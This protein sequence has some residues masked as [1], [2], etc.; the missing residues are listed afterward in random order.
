[1]QTAALLPQL[2]CGLR[3]IHQACYEVSDLIEAVSPALR[4][5]GLHTGVTQDVILRNP[6]DNFDIVAYGQAAAAAA[7]QSKQVRI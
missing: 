3:C 4:E 7:P 2:T 6:F 5:E 1:M